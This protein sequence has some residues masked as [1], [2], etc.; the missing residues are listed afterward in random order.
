MAC[1]HSKMLYRQEL[2]NRQDPNNEPPTNGYAQP[3]IKY[4]VGLLANRMHKIV[5]GIQYKP[6][7]YIKLSC[8]DPVGPK[9]GFRTTT[10]FQQLPSKPL[11]MIILL[12]Y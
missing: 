2:K 4:F 12:F 10:C 3:S 11:L 6:I 7:Q 1:C 9:R 5:A 8:F